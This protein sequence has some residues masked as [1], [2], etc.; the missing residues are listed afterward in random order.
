MNANRLP[1]TI[2]E[3]LEHLRRSLAGADPALIQDALYDAE[4]YLRSELAENPGRSEAEVIAA[5]ASSYGAPEEVADIYRDTEVTVQTALRAP[6]PKPRAS[7]AGR[8]FGVA[9]DPRAY[10]S[11]F[12]MVLAL[13]TGIFYF[14]WVVAGLSLSAGL[15]ILII[16]IPFVI[17]FFG[18]VRI[19]SLVEGRIVEVMLGERMP[20]RPL[21][22][23]RGRS[24]L[25]RIGDMFTDPRSWSTLLYM[26]LMLPLGIFYF[27]VAVAMGSLS[28]GLLLSPLALLPGADY[29]VW[30]WGFDLVEDA[31]WLLPL[32]SLVGA[33]LLFVTLHLARAIGRVHGLLAKHLLVKTA[34]YA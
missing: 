31:A 15:A 24:I 11:L 23:A 13:A 21:Y 1:T 3:Y 12:Y 25:Q 19:L 9:A 28:L 2:P 8:F 20:R 6:P 34:Q 4:E 32:V 16:G 18:S 5:V 22:N 17:L 14:T 30:F 7:L 10:A 33:L 29:A 26:L 27:T